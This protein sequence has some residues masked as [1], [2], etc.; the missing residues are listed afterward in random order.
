VH[1]CGIQFAEPVRDARGQKPL[2]LQQCRQR[3]LIAA[4]DTV[5]RGLT[6]GH[7]HR[8]RLFVVKAQRWHLGATAEPVAAPRPWVGLDAAAEVPQLHDQDESCPDPVV[9]SALPSASCPATKPPHHGDRTIGVPHRVI[10]P[11]LRP[12]GA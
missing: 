11:P 6:Q 9:T 5:E 4:E 3:G 10:E 7:R 2:Q 12:W 1:E 8:E